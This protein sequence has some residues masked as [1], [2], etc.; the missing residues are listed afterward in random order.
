MIVKGETS[1]VRSHPLYFGIMLA[2]ASTIPIEAI[3]L[4][5]EL[6]SAWESTDAK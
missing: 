1:C 4:R 3:L 6:S 5:V 2:G